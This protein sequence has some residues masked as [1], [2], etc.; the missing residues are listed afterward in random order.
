M[1]ERRLAARAADPAPAS[2]LPANSEVTAVILAEDP[3]S[4]SNLGFGIFWIGFKPGL[5]LVDV[6]RENIT[7]ITGF[8]LVAVVS[9]SNPLS[10]LTGRAVVGKGFGGM[11]NGVVVRAVN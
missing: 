2:V 8:E 11:Q 10:C 6:R 9:N 7:V 1:T 5:L 4:K 3:E